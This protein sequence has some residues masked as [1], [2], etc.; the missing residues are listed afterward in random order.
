M[1]FAVAA[2]CSRLTSSSPCSSVSSMSRFISFS[3]TFALC[4][5]LVAN[6]PERLRR[7][8]FR[9][10]SS[11]CGRNGTN[12]CQSRTTNVALRISTIRPSS[13]IRSFASSRASLSSK[14]P[15]P[16]S[17]AETKP[18]FAA[19]GCGAASAAVAIPVAAAIPA[20]LSRRCEKAGAECSAQKKIAGEWL[21][22]L[23]GT[24][25]SSPAARAHRT[26]KPWK[27]FFIEHCTHPPGKPHSPHP[28]AILEFFTRCISTTGA[29]VVE[30]VTITSGRF[31]AQLRCACVPSL[32]QSV[33]QRLGGWT[34]VS[35][36]P[37]T[38]HSAHIPASAGW[39]SP[40]LIPSTHP[41]QNHSPS[42][43]SVKP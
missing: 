22:S 41:W 17:S 16:G 32:P 12:L 29:H 5:T 36:P 40:C 28:S 37:G 30:G 15:S 38:G 20:A 11:G 23:S 2:S 42:G 26:W 9:A 7:S 6:F 19:V 34:R 24:S 13:F 18:P 43:T 27:Q 25:F 31:P 35:A 21:S 4:M 14:M 1:D 8:A 3:G 10:A 39:P 33:A